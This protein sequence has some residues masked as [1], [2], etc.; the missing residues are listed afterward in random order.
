MRMGKY[1]VFHVSVSKRQ[2]ILQRIFPVKYAGS[3]VKLIEKPK[4]IL[5]NFGFVPVKVLIR[6]ENR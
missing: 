4:E 2:S 3:K 5:W 6:Y 1:Q